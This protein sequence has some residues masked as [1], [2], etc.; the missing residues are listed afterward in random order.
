MKTWS[1]Y[2][3]STGRFVK[4]TWSGPLT[5]L[6]A[7]TPSGCAVIDGKYDDL[8]QRVDLKTG[9]VVD[10]QPPQPSSEHEWQENVANGRPRWVLNAE[11]ID[12][13]IKDAAARDALKALDEKRVRAL[14]ELYENP[15]ALMDD[16]SR[17]D[18]Y[19]RSLNEQ[20]ATERASLATDTLPASDTD[21]SSVSARP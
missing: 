8:S 13:K 17:V 19:L 16:G 7:N 9:E 20:A 10:Y 5:D 15:D 12:A 6:D 21:L 2:D 11:A 14:S 1:F 4:R 18:A 3:P